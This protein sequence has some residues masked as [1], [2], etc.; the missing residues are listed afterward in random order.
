MIVVAV[1][2]EIL[3]GVGPGETV[4]TVSTRKLMYM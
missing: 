3:L 1:P 2:D 4:V